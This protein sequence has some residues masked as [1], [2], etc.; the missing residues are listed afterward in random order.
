MEKKYFVRF[1]DETLR[2]AM[3]YNSKEG[4]CSLEDAIEDAEKEAKADGK[5]AMPFVVY[6]EVKDVV[7]HGI[8]NQG[9]EKN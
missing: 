4:Y 5:R 3:L 1:A 6:D 7:H 2:D 8:A 9:H